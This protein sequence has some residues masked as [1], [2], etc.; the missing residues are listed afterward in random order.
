MRRADAR[1]GLLNLSQLAFVSLMPFSWPL[2]GEKGVL[3]SQVIYS[4]NC[5]CSPLS[6]T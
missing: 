5:R 6:G 4:F 2:I 3:L 1:L